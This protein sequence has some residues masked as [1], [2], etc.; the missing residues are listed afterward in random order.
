MKTK[1]SWEEKN[2]LFFS[3]EETKNDEWALKAA[4]DTHP[5]Y[6]VSILQFYLQCKQ[7]LLPTQQSLRWP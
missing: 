4:K 5:G 1:K 6:E 3:P 7:A 2:E